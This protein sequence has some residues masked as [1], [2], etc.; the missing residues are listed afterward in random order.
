MFRSNRIVKLAFVMLGAVTLMTEAAH[1]RPKILSQQ[2]TP[3]VTNTP[4]LECKDK[5]GC[6]VPD[7]VASARGV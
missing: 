7:A 1:I 5:C 4:N 2:I 3:G 6:G